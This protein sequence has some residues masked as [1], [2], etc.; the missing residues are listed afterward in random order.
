MLNITKATKSN[1]DMALNIR[2]ETLRVVNALPEE[3]IF[4]K[5][6]IDTTK[7]YFKNPNQTTV[8]AIDNEALDN[9]AIGCATI[10]YI[11]IMPT[12][13]HASGKRAHIMNVYVRKNYRRQGIAFQ[14]MSLLIKEAIQKGISEIS[15]DTTESG[16]PLY[17]QCGFKKTDE[18]MVLQLNYLIY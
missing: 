17:E 3:T 12:F 13:D 4:D 18:G 2:L 10:C 5:S 7:D 6:L 15:L 16:T 9:E 11:N 1:L 14:M 8:L